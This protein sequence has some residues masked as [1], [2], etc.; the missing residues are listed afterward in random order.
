MA[1]QSYDPTW[2]VELAKAQFP[3][4]TWLHAALAACIRAEPIDPDREEG[5]YFID[6]M[7]GKF[8]QN[9]ILVSHTRGK[10]VLDILKDKRVGGMS[11]IKLPF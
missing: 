9:V 4:E 10:I 11:F 3:N 1:F 5:L 7:E 8:W 2:L 6:R